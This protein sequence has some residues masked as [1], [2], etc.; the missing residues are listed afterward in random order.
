[1]VTSEVCDSL[2]YLLYNNY[3]RFV[4]KLYMQIV[5]IPIG[6]NY[7]HL[8]TDLFLFCYGEYFMLSF[9]DNTHAGVTLLQDMQMTY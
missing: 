7:A 4:S 6:A 9:S 1:M 5:G 3:I 2:H 8:V